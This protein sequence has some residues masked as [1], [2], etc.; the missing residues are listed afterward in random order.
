MVKQKAP[1]PL[2]P[3]GFPGTHWHFLC[4]EGPWNPTLV[5]DNA[6]RTPRGLA[7]WPA[8]S[9][10]SPKKFFPREK[11]SRNGQGAGE[12][13]WQS[14]QQGGS[15][16]VPGSPRGGFIAGSPRGGFIAVTVL[17]NKRA[18]CR[19]PPLGP[20]HLSS[21][22]QTVLRETGRAGLS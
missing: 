22:G 7:N 18:L 8:K 13:W 9:P 11:N 16:S 15:P 20:K 5:A 1:S 14:K 19:S 12:V 6:R 17:L 4:T 10:A 2:A 3:S 21:Q